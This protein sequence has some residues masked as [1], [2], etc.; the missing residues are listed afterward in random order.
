MVQAHESH[1]IWDSNTVELISKEV[2]PDV[3]A[4][5]E[6]DADKKAPEARAMATSSGFVIGDKGILIIDTMLTKRLYDQLMALIRKQSSKPILYAVNTG[7]HGDHS[8]GN[9]WLPA[10][11]KI[12][13]HRATQLKHLNGLKEEISNSIAILGA[14]RGI[15]KAAPKPADLIID[16]GSQLSVNL[17]NKEV[18]VIDFSEGIAGGELYVWLKAENVIWAGNSVGAEAP[19]LP[20]LLDDDAKTR[21]ATYKK[22]RALVSKDVT[23]VPGHGRPTGMAAVVFAENYLKH[24]LENVQNEIKR[25][26]GLEEIKQNVKAEPF[27]GYE[28]FD[29]A[30]YKINIPSIY[31]ML[32]KV[33]HQSRVQ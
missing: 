17:G 18:N 13:Q 6:K 20:W 29:F 7:N 31:Y 28:L 11:T 2:A 8:F 5:Y 21:L 9:T 16:E 27:T 23:I 33:P 26:K 4:V 25:G 19:A 3:F 32:K 12:I 10:E 30:H 1:P 14:G 15:E 22:L 24:L